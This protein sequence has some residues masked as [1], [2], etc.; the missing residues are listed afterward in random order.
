MDFGKKLNLFG[1]YYRAFSDENYK[2]IVRATEHLASSTFLVL[3][4]KPEAER[5]EI[6]DRARVLTDE[7]MDL[8]DGENPMSAALASLVA[9]RSIEQLVQQQ[10]EQ[11][12]KSK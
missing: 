11:R 2:E 4:R 5:R 1:E 8:V 12:R 3:G 10:A 6:I 9:I 7:I